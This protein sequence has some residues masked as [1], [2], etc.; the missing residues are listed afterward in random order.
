M[1]YRFTA[2][3]LLTAALLVSACGK[4]E[5]AAEATTPDVSAVQAA[6]E[7]AVAEQ[8]VED[9]PPAP[10]DAVPADSADGVQG[11]DGTTVRPADAASDAAGRDGATAQ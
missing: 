10:A 7:P 4:K 11:R 9:V 3:A 1:T 6:P 2:A 5:E 8:V